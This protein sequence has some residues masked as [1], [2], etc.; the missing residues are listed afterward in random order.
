[1]R[2]AEHKHCVRSMARPD[3]PWRR[4]YHSSYALGKHLFCSPATWA[5]RRLPYRRVRVL[6]K[7]ADPIYGSYPLSFTITPSSADEIYIR[8]HIS[9]VIQLVSDEALEQALGHELHR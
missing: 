1:M 9:Q 2:A 5:N 4:V 8:S 7:L 6:A 3:L